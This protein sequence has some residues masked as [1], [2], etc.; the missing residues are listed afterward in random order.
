MLGTDGRLVC[1]GAVTEREG[2]GMWL[3][4]K[5]RYITQTV[6]FIIGNWR[7]LQVHYGSQWRF[8]GTV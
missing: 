2:Q 5:L 3:Q 6:W 4:R 8:I 7:F 1:L